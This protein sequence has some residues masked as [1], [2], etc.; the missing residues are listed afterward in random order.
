M[1]LAQVA[2][3]FAASLPQDAP[4]VSPQI[5]VGHAALIQFLVE[6]GDRSFF[7]LL[8][9]ASWCPVEGIR[10]GSRWLEVFVVA[11]GAMAALAVR[12]AVESLSNAALGASWRTGAGLIV[13]PVVL[14]MLAIKA[15]MDYKEA[16]ASARLTGGNRN[17]FA[18]S[19]S[20]N[21]N[22]DLSDVKWSDVYMR[23]P[24]PDPSFSPQ[25]HSSYGSVDA[26]AAAREDLSATLVKPKAEADGFGYMALEFLIPFVC[27]LAVTSTDPVH[28]AAANATK[29]VVLGAGA[30]ALAA[31]LLAVFLGYVLE[32]EVSDR[33][34]LLV[35]AT[36]FFALAL[37]STSQAV[38]HFVEAPALAK[39]GAAAL[40]SL[41]TRAYHS[42]IA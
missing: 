24:E 32:R 1:V 34:F 10:A 8:L 38:L 14:W 2:V 20:N 33:R 26:P 42:V 7:V 27:V 18:E 5:S 6:V 30:G 36:A 37:V 29:E 9:L 15:F 16:N 22:S 23:P 28:G 12:L 25:H 21:K 17:P 31:I 41:A 13:A 39:K 11:L 19:T 4:E 3:A 40:L 35:A